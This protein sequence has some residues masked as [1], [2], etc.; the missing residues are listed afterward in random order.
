MSLAGLTFCEV[1]FSAPKD[2]AAARVE[3]AELDEPDWV[4]EDCAFLVGWRFNCSAFARA[5][6]CVRTKLARF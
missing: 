2:R 5:F 3:E 6:S 1:N 4:W